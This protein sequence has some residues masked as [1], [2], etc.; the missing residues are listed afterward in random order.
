MLPWEQMPPA[1]EFAVNEAHLEEMLYHNYKEAKHLSL[2]TS[3]YKDL[4][5]KYKNMKKF[6]LNLPNANLGCVNA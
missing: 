2:V 4:E 5:A 3:K 1:P 6:L